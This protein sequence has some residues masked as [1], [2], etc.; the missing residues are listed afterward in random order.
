M[1][2]AIANAIAP[3]RAF[4]DR[5]LLVNSITP[6]IQSPATPKRTPVG[7]RREVLRAENTPDTR[8]PDESAGALCMTDE[9]NG[10]RPR[11]R[12][13]A[14][15]RTNGTNAAATVTSAARKRRRAA[16]Y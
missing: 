4:S 6:S 13:K 10:P 12:R 16:K 14:E 11:L 3:A 9:G 5:G 1:C 15:K 2:A 8:L 7:S